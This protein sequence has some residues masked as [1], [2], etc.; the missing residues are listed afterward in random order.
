LH[1]FCHVKNASWIVVS[2]KLSDWNREDGDKLLFMLWPVV[3]TPFF[4]C[5]EAALCLCLRREQVAHLAA[6]RQRVNV[7]CVLALAA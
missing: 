1:Q 6:A 3:A 7:V 2:E 4:V 5:C